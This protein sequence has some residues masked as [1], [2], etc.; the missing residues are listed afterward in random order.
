MQGVVHQPGF[1]RADGGT[2]I[3]EGLQLYLLHR[4]EAQQQVVGRL[5]AN[6]GDVGE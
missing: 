6:A 2:E 5:L 1:C 4:A 3:F